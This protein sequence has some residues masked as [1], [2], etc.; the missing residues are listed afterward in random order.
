MRGAIPP[1]LNTPSWHG[2]QLKQEDN[3]TFSFYLFSCLVM[4]LNTHTSKSCLGPVLHTY[5]SD[6]TSFCGLI[7]DV[8]QRNLIPIGTEQEAQK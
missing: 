8:K 3:F 1:L 5:I 2:T 6:N 7:S 4:N